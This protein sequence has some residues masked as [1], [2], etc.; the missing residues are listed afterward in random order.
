MSPS[1]T[2]FE[3]PISTNIVSV[4]LFNAFNS[5][6]PGSAPFFSAAPG[7]TADEASV[8]LKCSGKSFLVEHPPTGK[9]VIFDL[10]VRKDVDGIVPKYRDAFKSDAL[11]MDFGPDVAETLIS[12]GIDLDTIDAII[13]RC[14]QTD[15][16]Y[17]SDIH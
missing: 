15:N 5:L 2:P 8:S 1:N 10:G 13:W 7:S 6:S 17:L 4:K 11:K 14:V 16:W 3:L 12:A 9:K